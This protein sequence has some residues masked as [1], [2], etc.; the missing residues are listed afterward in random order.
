MT[1]LRTSLS[2]MLAGVLIVAPIVLFAWADL[3]DWKPGHG[4]VASATIF[5]FTIAVAWLWDD[6]DPA[7][8]WCKSATRQRGQKT[9]VNGHYEY[10]SWAYA[11]PQR[12]LNR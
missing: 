10:A 3:V 1:R 6:L 4:I 12:R 11:V 5:V 2:C 8:E 9:G 7:L